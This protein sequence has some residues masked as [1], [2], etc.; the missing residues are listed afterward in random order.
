MMKFHK[1]FQRC[2]IVNI[3]KNFSSFPRVKVSKK[4]FIQRY[5]EANNAPQEK[6]QSMAIIVESLQTYV[7]IGKEMIGIEEVDDE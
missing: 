3:L 2:D 4:E 6:A 7:L 1:I 5:I